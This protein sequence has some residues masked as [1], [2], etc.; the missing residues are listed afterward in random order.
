M[1]SNA[2]HL[3]AIQI[4][5]KKD[6][7]DDDTKKKQCKLRPIGQKV[8]RVLPQLSACNHLTSYRCLTPEICDVLLI[9]A[10]FQLN[11][12]NRKV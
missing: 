10:F 8:N 2:F 4:N 9:A 12:V 1:K 5:I 3:F 7:V 6:A 11:Y